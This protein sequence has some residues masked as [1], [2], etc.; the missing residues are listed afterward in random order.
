MPVLPLQVIVT[1]ELEN[2]AHVWIRALTDKMEEAVMKRLIAESGNICNEHEKKM[3]K[4]ISEVTLNA[5]I[6]L[7]QKMR[8]DA[9]MGEVMMKLRK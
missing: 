1:G 4:S 7:I 3:V 5:N 2:E 9:G 8:G 6:R